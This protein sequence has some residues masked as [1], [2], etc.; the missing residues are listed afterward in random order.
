MKTNIINLTYIQSTEIN[1]N[2]IY[3]HTIDV[4]HVFWTFFKKEFF[5]N[6]PFH[7]S[8]KLHKLRK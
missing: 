1:T 4:L 6:F 5:V 2:N 8:F 3:F 7:K